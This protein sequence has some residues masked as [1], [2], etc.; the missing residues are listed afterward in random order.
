MKEIE[1]ERERERERRVDHYNKM[2]KS[3]VQP[4]GCD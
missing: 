2:Y 1:R 4:S 3:D